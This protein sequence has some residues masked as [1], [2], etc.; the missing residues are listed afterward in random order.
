MKIQ[1]NGKE[2]DFNGTTVADLVKKYKLKDDGVV[3]E[4]N[5]TIVQRDTYKKEILQEGD[6]VEIVMFVGGG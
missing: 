2:I 5:E 6:V 4:K 1:V 3:V